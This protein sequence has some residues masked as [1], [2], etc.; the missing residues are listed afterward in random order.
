MRLYFAIGLAIVLGLTWVDDGARAQAD[1]QQLFFEGFDLLKNGKVREAAAILEDGL[2]LEPDNALAHFYLA[3]SYLAL[4]QTDEARSHYR[5]SLRLEPLSNFSEQ[6]KQRL[7]MLS[8]MQR[9]DAVR[10]DGSAETGQTTGATVKDCD[11]CPAEP[12]ETTG[13]SFK[14]CDVCAASPSPNPYSPGSLVPDNGLR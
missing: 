2:R 3:E 9:P 1:A 14:D 11:V 4:G 5:E 8:G 10:E 6:A 13:P 7:N 12:G